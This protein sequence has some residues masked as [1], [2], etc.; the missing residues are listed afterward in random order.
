MLQLLV[1]QALAPLSWTS[2]AAAAVKG[3]ERDVQLAIDDWQMRGTYR[4]TLFEHLG[5]QLGYGGRRFF[6]GS[7]SYPGQ[8]RPIFHT[9]TSGTGSAMVRACRAFA[10]LPS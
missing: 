1:Q 10:L 2:A 4:R 7:P 6:V 5:V 3:S 8:A 9:T